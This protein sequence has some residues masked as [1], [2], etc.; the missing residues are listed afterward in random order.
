MSDQYSSDNSEY[1]ELHDFYSEELAEVDLRAPFV[2]DDVRSAVAYCA[3]NHHSII[4]TISSCLQNGTDISMSYMLE[5]ILKCAFY[6]VSKRVE[7]DIVW[8]SRLISEYLSIAPLFGQ[9][10]RSGLINHLLDACWKKL[11]N[12]PKASVEAVVQ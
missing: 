2:N 4:K 8:K 9:T 5:A 12:L 7:Y 3:M 10:Q 11:S 6:E 1:H